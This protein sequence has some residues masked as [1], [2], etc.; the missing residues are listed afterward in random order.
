MMVE[1]SR[2]HSNH[3]V[4]GDG[5][6]NSDTSDLQNAA[7][8]LEMTLRHTEN[9][10]MKEFYMGIINETSERLERSTGKL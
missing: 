8:C 1:K 9:E 10:A 2:D 7:Q 3:Q 6:G 5:G 4:I